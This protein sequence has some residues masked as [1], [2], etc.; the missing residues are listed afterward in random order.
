MKRG[1]LI[2]ITGIDGC[3][4]TTQTR[5]LNNY[6]NSKGLHSIA[7]KSG[8]S[9]LVGEIINKINT[10]DIVVTPLTRAL[11]YAVDYSCLLSEEILPKL[12]EGTNIIM[13]RYLYSSL[14]YNTAL[15][16]DIEWSKSLYS[17]FIWPDLVI[18]ID[19]DPGICYER[20]IKGRRKLSVYEVGLRSNI[21]KK[22]F[23]IF[24]NKIRNLYVHFAQQNKNFIVINGNRSIDEVHLAIKEVIVEKIERT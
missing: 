14:V 19:T 12:K 22:E 13:D 6:L 9:S 17:H 4:K 10:E 1:K 8:S 3:G 21:N 16:L 24:Q 23:L 5:L 15:G 18:W 11:I 20:I 7:I 2:E